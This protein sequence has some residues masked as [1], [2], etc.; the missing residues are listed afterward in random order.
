[1][2]AFDARPVRTAIMTNCALLRA[3]L[4]PFPGR[5]DTGRGTPPSFS[6]TPLRIMRWFR[7]LA[8]STKLAISF[9][10]VVALT[11]GLGVFALRGTSRVNVAA[12]DI[13]QHWLP[14]VRH[15]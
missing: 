5:T 14:S 6:Y 10:L 15:S 2:R 1:M 12:E 7:N 9:A 11:G 3:R 4:K 13:G 8:L